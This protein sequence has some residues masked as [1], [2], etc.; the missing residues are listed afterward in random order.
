MDVNLIRAIRGDGALDSIFLLVTNLGSEFGYI[1]ILTVLYLLAPRIGRQIGLWFGVNVALNTA[2]KYAF[3]LPRPYTVDTS[4]GTDLTR[5]TAAGPGLPSGHA[6]NAAF[7]WGYLA[8]RVSRTW[9]WALSLTII[10]LISVS[11]LYLGVHFLDDVLLGLALGGSMV[12]LVSR[13]HVPQVAGLTAVGVLV[14]LAGLSSLLSEEWSREFGL[15]WGFLA[16]GANFKP[17]SGLALK[18]I[19]VVLGLGLVFALYLGSSLLLPE[20]WKRSGIGSL[21]RYALLTYAIT[22]LYPRAALRLLP[23]DE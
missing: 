13:L 1:A 23:R 20:D 7:V 9:V 17:P 2:L 21:L 12:W 3:D 18:I 11:R 5:A 15:L 10:L 4:I 16:A 14:V 6:Q 22:E 19:F 8:L